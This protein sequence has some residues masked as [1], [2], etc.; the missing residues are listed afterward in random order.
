MDEEMLSD[1]DNISIKLN[2]CYIETVGQLK[3]AEIMTDHMKSLR[4]SLIPQKSA[5]EK[6]ISTIT[7]RRSDDAKVSPVVTPFKL[8]HSSSKSSVASPV[9]TEIKTEVKGLKQIIA[10]LINKINTQEYTIKTQSCKIKSLLGVSS[11][12]TS[13][14]RS[15][16]KGV[17]NNKSMTHTRVLSGIYTTRNRMV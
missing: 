3:S 6:K 13:R 10:L 16:E 14:V 8:R 15:S 2:Q 9:L 17:N 1:I 11:K 4:F 7:R 12:Q 5:S